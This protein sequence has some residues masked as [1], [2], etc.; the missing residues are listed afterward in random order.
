QLA[1]LEVL[2]DAV[3]KRQTWPLQTTEGGRDDL[4]QRVAVIDGRELAQPCPIRE[5][6]Q[7]LRRRLDRKPRLANAT[8]TRQRHQRCPVEQRDDASDVVVTTHE[9]R[10]LNRQV[11]RERAQRRQR[12]EL[13]NETGTR[14]LEH[15]LRTSEVAQRMFAK[16]D[17]LD[18]AVLQQ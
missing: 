7:D 8:R 2:H 11:S 9:R 15:A 6:R 12:R 4:S 17:K 3:G 5:S 1:Y 14:H 13:P 10:Q 16:V 18:A